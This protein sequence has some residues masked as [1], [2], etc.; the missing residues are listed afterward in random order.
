MQQIHTVTGFVASSQQQVGRALLA[1]F[2][3]LGQSG[4]AQQQH[5][6]Q[7]QNIFYLLLILLPERW[8]ECRL[9]KPGRKLP[10][11]QPEVL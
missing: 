10:E 2:A 6:Q 9:M 7:G 11:I 3:L 1:E 8:R 5:Q 4:Y